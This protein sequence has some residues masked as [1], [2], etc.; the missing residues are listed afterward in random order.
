MTALLWCVVLVAFALAAFAVRRSSRLQKELNKL[1]H[2]HFHASG[3]LKRIPEEIRETVQPLR[4][5]L[6][7]V[8]S[9][10]TVPREM[11]LNG[12]LYQDVTALEAQHMLDREGLD[13]TGD[14]LLID[15]RSPKEHAIRRI[16]R[17]KLVPFEE[18]DTRYREEIPENASKVFVYCMGGERSRMACDFLS[19]KGYTN[20]YNI[21][22]GLQA[23]RGAFEGEE[24]VSLIQIDRTF[25]SRT[26]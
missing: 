21:R 13:G 7:K 26:D 20:L 25:S 22:D 3:R 2:D 5:Q 23:W 10:G 9:G 18:L 6:A 12:R 19:Q 4:V 8:A 16:P 11:I 1:K 14:I 15:V 17:A 24:P